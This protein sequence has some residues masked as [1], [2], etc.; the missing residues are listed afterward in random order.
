MNYMMAECDRDGVIEVDVMMRIEKVI[1]VTSSPATSRCRV[2][3]HGTWCPLSP[4]APSTIKWTR[5][6]DTRMNLIGEYKQ[7]I[8]QYPWRKLEHLF[9]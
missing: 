4:R 5:P 7:T 6:L 1:S 9:N 2:T 3:R 8:L